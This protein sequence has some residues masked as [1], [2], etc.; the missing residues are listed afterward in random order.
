ML[1]DGSL[2]H[3]SFFLLRKVIYLVIFI[4]LWD[5]QSKRIRRTE[6]LVR[7]RHAFRKSP[8]FVLSVLRE[9]DLEVNLS[10]KNEI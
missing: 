5:S 10:A 3:L 7:E 4:A 6:N 8:K 9:N 2:S 1:N